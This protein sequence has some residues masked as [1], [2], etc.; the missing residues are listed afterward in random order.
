MSEH[1]LET[2]IQ[3]TPNFV[4]QC[5]SRFFKT[6]VTEQSHKWRSSYDFSSPLVDTSG[7]TATENWRNLGCR[8]QLSSDAVLS[9]WVDGSQLSVMVTNRIQT[10]SPHSPMELVETQ[11]WAR[12]DYYGG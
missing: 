11:N 2:Q 5:G 7:R 4:F 6:V 9:F 1:G 12:D 8:S 3:A 10:V